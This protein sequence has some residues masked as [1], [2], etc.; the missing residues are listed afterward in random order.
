MRLLA[1]D[2]GGGMRYAAVA[3]AATLL[4]VSADPDAERFEAGDLAALMSPLPP[5]RDRALHER[6]LD[7]AAALGD[8]VL[9]DATVGTAEAAGDR[10]RN[11]RP[12]PVA[13]ARPR[14]TQ[15]ARLRA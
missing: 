12:T 8:P 6:L 3:L 9:R 2:L 10:V 1:G 13:T 5:A 14:A 7:C 15:P 11:A 4:A